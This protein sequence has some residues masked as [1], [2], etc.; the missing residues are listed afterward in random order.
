MSKF[1]KGSR[2]A[3]AIEFAFIFPLLLAMMFG[4][5]EYGRFLW[6]Q[7]TMLHGVEDA[8]RYAVFDLRTTASQSTTATNT[9]AYAKQH[10]YSMTKLSGMT[11]VVTYPT[12]AN[13]TSMVLVRATYPFKPLISGLTQA[14]NVTITVQ[15]A[16][17]LKSAVP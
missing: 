3:V 8:A 9:V 11:P 14:A 7:N 5:V 16:Q 6:I 12:G 2:G 17:P 10:M 15:S 1:L 13:G 4:V